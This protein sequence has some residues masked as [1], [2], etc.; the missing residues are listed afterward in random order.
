[1]ADYTQDANCEIA[2]LMDLNEN[3]LSDASGNSRT[4]TYD[5]D[6]AFGNTSN[7]NANITGYYTLDGNDSFYS[8]SSIDCS[9]TG[10]YAFW[11]KNNG[12]ANWKPIAGYYN[13]YYT[14]IIIQTHSNNSVYCEY[15]RDGGTGTVVGSSNVQDG[16]WHHIA[17]TWVAG[18]L[19]ILYL[20]G[21]S[22]G[23]GTHN[24]IDFNGSSNKLRIGGLASAYG[25]GDFSQSS[26]FS[27]VLSSTEIN[28]IMD[29]GLEGATATEVYTKQDIA[30][31]PADDTD[32]SGAFTAQNY[33]DVATD[34]NNYVTQSSVGQ[35]AMFLFKDQ[36]TYKAGCKITWKGKSDYA[37]SSSTVFLQMYNRTTTEWTT[38]DS[39]DATAANTEFTLTY[40][41]SDPTN[42]VDA[43]FW[44][45][46]RVY[47]RAL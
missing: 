10:S 33:T 25:T 35:Y 7:P 1:M 15:S 29:N 23:T 12:T 34:D 26:L 38:V 21:T 37:C 6:P 9:T 19:P 20:D 3:P 40:T 2:W 28:D 36:N 5:S 41:L 42:Y 32:L 24:L 47:Q 4:G 39:D 45:A 11:F 22:E 8:S 46:C 14:Q 18:N 17:I 44:V 13:D 43:S 27:D 30:S 31:L 16:E